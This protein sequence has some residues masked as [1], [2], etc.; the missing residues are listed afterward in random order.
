MK[1]Q[2]ALDKG[3]KE[4]CLEVFKEIEDVIDIIEVGTTVILKYGLEVVKKIRE[5]N[6]DI[7]LLADFKICDG[8]K[9]AA[10]FAFEAGADIVTV[11]GFTND[12]TIQGVITSAKN[13]NKKCLVDM[14]RIS[15]VIG[16]SKE[17]I[18]KG[19]DY[20]CLHNAHDVL[21]FDATLELI[22]QAS[23]VIDRSRIVWAGGVN[24][25][26]IAKLRAYEPEIIVVGSSVYGAPNKRDMLIQLRKE[27]DSRQITEARH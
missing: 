17:C 7:T 14:M 19:A 15:D 21:D 3:N 12:K 23:R 16:R 11:M 13:H 22:D 2:Y 20:I 25:E 1:L 9:T 8:G 18:D 4:E 27:Y 5:M 6:R 10:D 24:L 26:N